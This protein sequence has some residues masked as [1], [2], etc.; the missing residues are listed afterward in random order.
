MWCLTHCHSAL[1][2]WQQSNRS[3]VNWPR[4]ANGESVGRQDWLTPTT[5]FPHFDHRSRQTFRWIVEMLG[6][7][8]AYST[9]Q[10]LLVFLACTHVNRITQH[11]III[12]IQHQKLNRS[13]NVLWIR[14]YE[15]N[16]QQAAGNCQQAAGRCLCSNGRMQ[17]GL[18][19]AVSALTGRQ[20]FSV[21]NDVMAAILKV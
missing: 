9:M 2:Q 18:A 4:M 1:N 11:F 17:R 21:W 14:K 15:Q 8:L 6:S 12:I 20:H 19:D 16:C 3:V 5:G 13:M 7:W 10:Q